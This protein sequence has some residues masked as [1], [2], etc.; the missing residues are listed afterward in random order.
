MIIG[1]RLLSKKYWQSLPESQ[2][3]S[4]TKLP[5]PAQDIKRLR[6]VF[7][8]A[9][10][11]NQVRSSLLLGLKNACIN[12]DQVVNR[13][14]LY[15]EFNVQYKDILFMSSCYEFILK[16]EQGTHLTQRTHTRYIFPRYR[17]DVVHVD[18]C[19]CTSAAV[20][21]LDCGSATNS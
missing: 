20:R 1:L 17:W 18:M 14:K 7:V 10:S 15:K 2:V 4:Q 5:I 12:N 13:L 11:F 3:M 6:I 21:E 16:Y 9:A 8:G 19:R